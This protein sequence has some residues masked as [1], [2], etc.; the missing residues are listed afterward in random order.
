M[1]KIPYKI[2]CSKCGEMKH[3]RKEIMA[4]R[5]EKAGSWENLE[6]SYE[7]LKCRPK[8][9]KAVK[10]KTEITE[11]KSQMTVSEPEINEEQIKKELEA[12]GEL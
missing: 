2:K 11:P 9:T 8:K 12:N 4:A 1:E 6:K 10:K 5:I 3:A 7:C